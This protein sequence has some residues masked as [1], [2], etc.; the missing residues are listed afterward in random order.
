MKVI[1]LVVISKQISWQIYSISNQ[2]RI[3]TDSVSTAR[4]FRL[5]LVLDRL[6]YIVTILECRFDAGEL[7]FTREPFR[8]LQLFFFTGPFWT[9]CPF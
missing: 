7:P 9:D 2:Y 4:T 5:E 1:E 6:L 8:E 3:L